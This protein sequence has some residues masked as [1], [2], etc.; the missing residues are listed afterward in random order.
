MITLASK[1]VLA[2]STILASVFKLGYE[3]LGVGVGPTTCVVCHEVSTHSLFAVKKRL[4]LS[5]GSSKSLNGCGL[6]TVSQIDRLDSVSFSTFRSVSG[7]LGVIIIGLAIPIF[8]L[9][10]RSV[11]DFACLHFVEIFAI[12]PR[13]RSKMYIL[14]P[15]WRVQDGAQLPSGGTVSVTFVQL[16]GGW[17]SWFQGG[18]TYIWLVTTME[19]PDFVG[20][21]FVVAALDGISQSKKED[22]L[23]FPY[24]R[25]LLT[26]FPCVSAVVSRTLGSLNY[27]WYLL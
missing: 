3:V 9:V 20:M 13:C 4:A 19:F 11:R 27:L 5:I 7:L 21:T 22:M 23:V 25:G 1:I 12:L 8:S 26:F 17:A 6:V 18:Q 24:G 10:L 14:V 16:F 15:N 2:S